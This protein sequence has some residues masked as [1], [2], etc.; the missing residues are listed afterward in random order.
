MITVRGGVAAKTREGAECLP[1]RWPTLSN[2]ENAEKWCRPAPGEMTAYLRFEIGL[3]KD[4]GKDA[5]ATTVAWTARGGLGVVGCAVK[6]APGGAALHMVWV[7]G[8]G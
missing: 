4:A 5:G 6:A 2:R 3:G 8:L 1:L 7:I